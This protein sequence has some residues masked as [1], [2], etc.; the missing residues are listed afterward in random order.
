MYP[1]SNRRGT[2]RGRLQD[3]GEGEKGPNEQKAQTAQSQQTQATEAEKEAKERVAEVVPNK[4][5]SVGTM[6]HHHA[7]RYLQHKLV[8]RR[9]NVFIDAQFVDL[10]GHQSKDCPTTPGV[11]IHGEGQ[12]DKG[13]KKEEAAQGSKD[14]SFEYTYTCETEEGEDTKDKEGDK[15]G[16][17][18]DDGG[19]QPPEPPRSECLEDYFRQRTFIFVHH[20][21]GTED[22]LTDAMLIEA[23]K[24]K[25]LR[26]KTFS[27]EKDKGTGDLLED[28]PYNTHLRWSDDPIERDPEPP[29]HEGFQAQRQQGVGGRRRE[30]WHTRSANLKGGED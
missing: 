28:E 26:L 18:D 25:V 5:V 12:Q 24:Q 22:P 6:V 10:P 4:S 15:E 19:D 14:E 1:H 30:V 16:D 17:K 29:G 13:A 27:I 8:S 20:Y 3:R 21:A 23:A 9:C 7:D 2:K 11:K